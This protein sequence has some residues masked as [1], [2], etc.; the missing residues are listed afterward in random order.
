MSAQEGIILLLF[1]VYMPV[2]IK[3]GVGANKVVVR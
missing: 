3:Y 1:A 2:R